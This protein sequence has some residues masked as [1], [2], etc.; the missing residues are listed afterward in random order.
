MNINPEWLYRIFWIV[1]LSTLLGVPI[2]FHNKVIA[3]FL[4]SEFAVDHVEERLNRG[5]GF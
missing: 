4:P 2:D 5:E 3:T 1:F